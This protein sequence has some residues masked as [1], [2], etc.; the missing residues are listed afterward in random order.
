[1]NPSPPPPVFL[2][3]GH[4]MG[5]RIRE[6]DWAA[7]PLGAPAGWPPELQMALN[8]CLNSSFPTAIYWG[9]DLHVLYNDAWSVI[10]AERH[11][12][13]LGRPAR[14]VW[15]DIWGVVGPQLAQ[16][17]ATGEGIAQFEQMLPMERGGVA[18]E[19]WW[20]YSF[21]ALRNADG[22]IGGVFNQGN[23]VTG[24]VL[25]RRQ[26]Q[27]ELERLRDWFRQAPAPIALLRSPEHVF[28]IANDAYLALV[29]GRGLLGKS[30][31]EALPEADEQGFVALLDEVYRT[32]KP[33]IAASSPI[34]LQRAPGQPR[35]ERVLD[36]IYQPVVD[37]AGAV[38]GIFVLVADVTD[39]ARAESALRLSNWQLA[40]ERARLAATVEAEKRA[41]AALR[42]FNETLEAHVNLR[43]AQ[44]ER[45]VAEQ[46][47]IADRLRATF[48]T[49]LIHQGFLDNRGTLM[50]ANTTSL[51][52]IRAK[53]NDVVG[54]PFWETP[55]VTATPGLA[56]YTREAVAMALAGQPVRREM[57]AHLPIGTSRFDYS[58]RPV[59]NARGEVIGVVPEAVDITDR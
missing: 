13:A 5:Q 39:R 47:A 3:G 26:R 14:E 20:N 50:D 54:R 34:Q 32:G 22:R 21:T 53:L 56:E 44:L 41:Q 7:H 1:M 17:M 28:E 11:P 45:T 12:W 24:L 57:E 16:V 2:Q 43:T 48:E 37:A 46:G 6:F 42:R 27:A 36:F 35:E 55:W 8:L 33:Y 18:R 40:E 10:P 38:D 15:S 30:V 58:L 19:T 59:F 4:Q 29:G 49:S 23:E 9:P 31:K 52:A 51:Q 25:A